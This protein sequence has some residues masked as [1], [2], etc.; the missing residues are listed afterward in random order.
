MNVV[1]YLVVPVDVGNKASPTGD[2][3]A[4][5]TKS[6]KVIPT[7]KHTYSEVKLLNFFCFS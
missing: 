7:T 6:T 3:H 4:L 2:G 1:G 5:K